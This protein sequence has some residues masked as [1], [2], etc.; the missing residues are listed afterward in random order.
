VLRMTRMHIMDQQ[1]IQTIQPEIQPQKPLSKTWQIV[2]LAVAGVLV[3]GGVAAGSY[4]LWQKS[5][6]NSNQTA[7]TM[8]AKQCADGSYVGRTGP[9]CEFAPCPSVSASPSIVIDETA[10]WQTYKNE[11]YGFEIKYPVNEVKLT[12]KV[13]SNTGREGLFSLEINSIRTSDLDHQIPV[14]SLMI[15]ILNNEYGSDEAYFSKETEYLFR[16]P[17]EAGWKIV[18]FAGKKWIEIWGFAGFYSSIRL[19]MPHN[20]YIYGFD[21]MSSDLLPDGDI[22]GSGAKEGIKLLSQILSTFKFTDDPT[23][24]W[25]T[26]KNEQYG[27]EVKYPKETSRFLNKE[28]IYREN[29]IGVTFTVEG[30][31][32]DVWGIGVITKDGIEKSIGQD[33]NQFKDRKEKRENIIVDGRQAMMVTITTNQYE[34]WVSKTIFILDGDKYYRIGNGAVEDPNFELF[35]KSFHIIKK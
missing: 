15:E 29:D 7:C 6:S 33:G 21:F 19:E 10:D 28:W 34:G 14:H 13:S 24:G 26:Y 25:Q 4:Y 9:N 17:R 35:Y 30:F 11:K 31:I 3:V 16:P 23:T 2:A 12:E 5:S 27:F 18:N 1:P 8:E 20:K 32:D 22:S